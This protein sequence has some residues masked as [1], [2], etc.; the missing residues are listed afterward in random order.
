[1]RAGYER[2]EFHRGTFATRAAPVHG[3]SKESPDSPSVALPA[4]VESGGDSTARI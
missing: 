2:P 3:G 4:D 1:M